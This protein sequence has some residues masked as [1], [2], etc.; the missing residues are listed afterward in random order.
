MPL[1]LDAIYEVIASAPTDLKIAARPD[2]M[3]ERVV[4]QLLT[5]MEKKLTPENVS[6]A[7]R[8]RDYWLVRFPG[9]PDKTRASVVEGMLARVGALSS[10]TLGRLFGSEMSW[11][12]DLVYN[13]AITIVDCPQLKF[14]EAGRL[15]TCLFKCSFTRDVQ[16]RK[17]GLDT[18][19]VFLWCDEVQY[20][21]TSSDVMYATTARSSRCIT[22]LLTQSIS[23]LTAMLG[24]DMGAEAFVHSLLGNL[25]TKFFHSCEESRTCMYLAEL[26]GHEFLPIPSWTVPTG[27][28]GEGS[29]G[30]SASMGMQRIY[31]VEPSAIQALKTGGP[32]NDFKVEAVVFRG[33]QPFANGKN[34]LKVTI[35]QRSGVIQ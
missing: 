19:P 34:F 23:T 33:G 4:G 5:L 35:D 26:A 16:R 8:V 29:P 22:V 20:V 25:R 12:P 31:R 13:G 15:A 32:A 1:T 6:R 9:Y 7:L 14:G 21:L 17:V 2:L 27:V 28:A 11:T 10:G 3:N 24:G 30:P 18:R